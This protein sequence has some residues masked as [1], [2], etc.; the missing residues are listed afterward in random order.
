MRILIIENDPR[1][2]ATAE[3]FAAEVSGEHEVVIK[4]T[5]E[6]G[7]KE[8]R[9]RYD[10]LLTDLWLPTPKCNERGEFLGVRPAIEQTKEDA[11]WDIVGQMPAG[12]SCAL[13]ALAWSVQSV[14]IVT[15][16]NHHN[17]RLTATLDFLGFGGSKVRKFEFRDGPKDWNLAFKELTTS[18]KVVAT[19]TLR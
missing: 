10:V 16:S 18:K 15:D 2:I 14:A 1:H 9:R 7:I 3:Q 17:D 6:E 8:C 12:L 5:I 13:A 4:T 19:G 11:A